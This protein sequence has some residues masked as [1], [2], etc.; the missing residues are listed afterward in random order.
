MV[1][2]KIYVLARY[3]P[4]LR[5]HPVFYEAI[6]ELHGEVEI[7]ERPTLSRGKKLIEEIGELSYEENGFVYVAT[8]SLVQYLYENSHGLSFGVLKVKKGDE[9]RDSFSVFWINRPSEGIVRI[10]AR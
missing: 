4:Y 7:R 9:E 8:S 3:I 1:E 6:K 5:E 10:W 2:E